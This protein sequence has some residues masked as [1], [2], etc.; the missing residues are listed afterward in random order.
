MK[1][2]E[3]A[4]VPRDE[5]YRFVRGL[6]SDPFSVLGPHK[7]G[8]D[9]EIRVFRPDA[10][11]VDIV[12]DRE[13]E[14]PI[15]AERIDQ[16]GFFCTTVSGTARDVPYRLRITKFDGSEETTHDPYQYGPIINDID[17]HLFTEGQHWEIYEKFGAHLRTIGDATDVYFAVWTPN[18]QRVS[19]VG[20]FNDWDGRVNPMR[21]LLGAG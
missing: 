15:A 4:G 8:D 7:V 21:K 5:V 12:L 6:H 14:K 1:A 13:S 18:A 20:D 16:E 17:L 19:V 10:R 9:M 11:H 3:I 2:F